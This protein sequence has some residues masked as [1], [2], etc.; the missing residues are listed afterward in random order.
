MK[1]KKYI[2][3][4]IQEGKKRI[5]EELGEDAII[6]STRSINEPNGS[7]ENIIEIVAAIDPNSK[8]TPS[9]TE[10]QNL[11]QLREIDRL[12]DVE[13]NDKRIS[14]QM[15]QLFNEIR[16]LQNQIYELTEIVRFKNISALSPNARKLYKLL[17]DSGIS[18]NMALNT[19]IRLNINDANID[20][21]SSIAEA[22]KILLERITFGNV[23]DKR[24]SL[25]IIAF[26]GSN[27]SGKT[28]ALIKL[29][30][31]C[32]LVFE[33][34]VL[35][36]SA[37]NIKIG[38]ADQLQSYASIAGIQ[39]RSVNSNAELRNI[40]DKEKDYN[41]IFIDSA[42]TGQNNIENIDEINNILKGIEI[43]HKYLV[44]QSNLSK[45]AI[46]S[47]FNTFRK[48]KPTSIILTKTD[49]TIRY[50]EVTEALNSSLVPISYFSTGQNIP[51]DIEQADRKKLLEMLLPEL[52]TEAENAGN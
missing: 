23:I 32:K 15:N 31:I 51:D 11:F 33:G 48:W 9:T 22:G 6:L 10:N 12:P 49:E 30:I 46:K 27:G 47:E 40:I 38:G 17:L 26:V 24:D 25:Q 39:F 18:E 2:A 1:I 41:Y 20:L 8:S 35:I 7:G 3:A 42:G 29:A 52:Q 44:I 34:Q 43:T 4:N 19:I 21:K 36:V 28:T 14:M 45:S 50:G 13:E 5:F 16:Q 37:D